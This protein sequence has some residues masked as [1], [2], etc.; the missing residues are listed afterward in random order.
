MP[1]D[2]R[3][4]AADIFSGCGGLSL[5]LE[6][7][8]F[9]INGSIDKESHNAL[10][11][12]AAFPYGV[13]A[14]AD[15]TNISG[16]QLRT[17]I[18]MKNTKIDLLSFGQSATASQQ[19]LLLAGGPPCQGFSSMG[20]RDIEDPR[21]ELLFHFARLVV[22]T[23]TRYAIME[24]VS[25]LIKD[26]LFAKKLETFYEILTKGGYNI[27]A[28]KILRA[29][30]F[31]VPQK[32]D[33]VFFLIYRSGET[34]PKY[35]T[36]T[37]S[38]T[39][40]DRDLFALRTPTVHDALCDLPILETIED[41]YDTDTLFIDPLEPATLSPYILTLKG[42]SND[43]DDLSYPRDWDRTHLT[44]LQLTRHDK[45]RV[46][47]YRQAPFG[48]NI[49][50]DR[51]HKLD[52]DGYAPTLRAG[53]GSNTAARPVHPFEGRVITCREAARLHSFPD[54]FILNRKKIWGHR[55]IGNSVPPLMARAIAHEIR[56]AANI[57]AI[58]PDI[59]LPGM[60]HYDLVATGKKA[61]Q[62]L[63]YPLSDL[64]DIKIA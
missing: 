25:G 59:I 9:D 10:T 39:G 45:H 58:K 5:G 23:G 20:K 46:E 53:S 33:R 26:P 47:I 2:K 13:S 48:K 17:L 21:S 28:P 36:P 61:E 19:L 63:R 55:Q 43:P 12:H 24:N 14:T 64:P 44:G 7:G 22:Q 34:A 54:W 15:L 32:R 52:P 4:N 57:P 27:V 8:G 31:G 62:L 30:H 1:T 16:D 50:G 18:N 3:G 41:L 60:D 56:K 11:H 29:T 37:H 38:E 35:P 40:S 42:L 51:L 49:P 6:A